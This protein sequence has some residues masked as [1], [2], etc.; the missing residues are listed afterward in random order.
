VR[1]VYTPYEAATRFSPSR[2][3]NLRIRQYRTICQ[4]HVN[5]HKQRGQTPSRLGCFLDCMKP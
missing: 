1:I 2:Q 3:L 4:R 5:S